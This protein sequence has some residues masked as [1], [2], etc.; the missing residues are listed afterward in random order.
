MVSIPQFK[1]KN[2]YKLA[3]MDEKIMKDQE[4]MA[5]VKHMIQDILFANVNFISKQSRKREIE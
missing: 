1:E 4:I 2:V 5:Y 3:S